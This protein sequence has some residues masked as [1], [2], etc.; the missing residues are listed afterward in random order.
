MRRGKGKDLWK[1]INKWRVRETSKLHN[2]KIYGC[3]LDIGQCRRT[4]SKPFI[5]QSHLSDCWAIV[6]LLKFRPQLWRSSSVGLVFGSVPP[7]T[8]FCNTWSLCVTMS[9][10]RNDYICHN[11]VSRR[12]TMWPWL[13]RYTRGQLQ[14]GGQSQ[15]RDPLRIIVVVAVETFEF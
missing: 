5:F 15:R 2:R 8:D 1:D 10:W 6:L 7:A 12:L 14:G 4:F 3:K 11:H 9:M 13:L